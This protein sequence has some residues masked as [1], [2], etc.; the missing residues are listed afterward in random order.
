MNI[1]AGRLRPHAGGVEGVREGAVQDVQRVSDLSGFRS[2]QGG[3]AEGAIR[4][5]ELGHAIFPLF[6]ARGHGRC[7][8]LLR[9]VRLLRN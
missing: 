9:H 6:K 5:Y 1:W 8:G 2:V 4:H 3:L 7:D